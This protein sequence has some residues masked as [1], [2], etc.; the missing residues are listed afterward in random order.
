MPHIFSDIKFIYEVLE[1]IEDA[2]IRERIT[3]GACFNGKA[4]D[5]LVTFDLYRQ[6]DLVLGMRYH[7]NVV[8]IGMNIP[9]IMLGTLNNQ[10]NLCRDLNIFH[11]CVVVNEK[12]FEKLLEDKI[13]YALQNRDK[14]IQENRQIN[15][16]LTRENAQYMLSIKEWLMEN[17]VI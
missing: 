5:G 2:L 7:A 14:L 3:I 17:G 15:E 11:R 4:T 13:W 12:G 16:R 10:I 1:K 8:P 9:T 6:C